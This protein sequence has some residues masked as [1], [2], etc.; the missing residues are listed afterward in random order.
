MKNFH[1]Q[2]LIKK[3]Y[4]TLWHILQCPHAQHWPTTTFTVVVWM[5]CSIVVDSAF[6]WRKKTNAERTN[7]LQSWLSF[8]FMLWFVFDFRVRSEQHES[9]LLRH[10]LCLINSSSQSNARSTGSV[11]ITQKK[12]EIAINFGSNWH[13][14]WTF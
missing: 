6:Q 5:W 11:K 4:S 3:F 7:C 10:F 14:W 1:C 2:S 9:G 13:S 12:N 8:K